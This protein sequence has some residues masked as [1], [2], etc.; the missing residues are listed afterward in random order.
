[1]IAE[2][3]KTLAFL[4]GGQ[5]RLLAGTNSKTAAEK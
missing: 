1:M 2:I 3:L 5:R 4:F